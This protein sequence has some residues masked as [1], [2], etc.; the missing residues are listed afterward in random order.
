MVAQSMPTPVKRSRKL[1]AGDIAAL[2]GMKGMS[3][4]GDTLFAR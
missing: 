2:I 4:R 3:R 1:L